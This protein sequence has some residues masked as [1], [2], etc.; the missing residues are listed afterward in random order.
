MID[1]KFW[2]STS[3]AVAIPSN[4]AQYM[5]S[6]PSWL[7]GTYIPGVKR[8]G[9]QADYQSNLVSLAGVN[10]SSSCINAGNQPYTCVSQNTGSSQIVVYLN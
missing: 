9:N 4:L 5:E 6:N 8:S 10:L 1:I 7:G 3:Q 2:S